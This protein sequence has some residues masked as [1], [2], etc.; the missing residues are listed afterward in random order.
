[1]VAQIPGL[2]RPRAYD[3]LTPEEKK[4]ICNGCGTTGR[5]D[6]IPDHLYGLSICEACHIHDFMYFLGDTWD[7]KKDADRIFLINMLRIISNE[8]NSILNI[9]LKR[10]RRLRALSYYKAV[11]NFGGLPFWAGKDYINYKE[12]GEE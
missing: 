9:L 2:I 5:L 1:M 6:F 12:K 11:V 3:R 4:N 10:L 8:P 7:D